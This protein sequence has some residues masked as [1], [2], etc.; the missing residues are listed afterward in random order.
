[1][2]TKDDYKSRIHRPAYLDYLGFRQ[3]DDEGQVTHERRFL[4]LFASSAYSE[5][6]A[7]IPLLRDKAQAILRRSGYAE[8]SHGGKAI[9]DV[10]DTLPRDELFQ[11]RLDDL[12]NTVERIAH[13]KERRQVRLFVR[14][15][16]YGRFLSCLVYLPRDRYTTAVRNRMQDL[17]IRRLG[18]AS[19]DY[20]AR[21]SESVLARLHFVVRMPVGDS[22]GDLD[23]RALERELTQATRSWN[24]EFAEVVASSR[25]EPEASEDLATLV[26]AL[27]EGYKEDYTAKQGMLDLQALI[28][29]DHGPDMAM[30]M[31]R[32]DRADDEADLRLKI[33]RR[34]EPLSLSRSCRTCR[35]SGSTSW[36]SDRTSCR[37]AGT[38]APSSTTSG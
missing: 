31:Y 5:A 17:L 4:G 16:P 28:D 9:M 33:F 6:V 35:S 34:S 32:P 29:L 22:L 3:F 26:G 1:M 25:E 20:T 30:A 10:L 21:V 11:A 27:P 36:T 7:R 14:R 18:G 12:A 19:I 24:D 8:S 23:V 13:L 37:S 2:I 38:D 15:D